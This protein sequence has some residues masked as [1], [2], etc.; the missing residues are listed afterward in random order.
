[1]YTVREN[2]VERVQSLKHRLDTHH[3]TKLVENVKAACIYLISTKNTGNYG[4]E[5]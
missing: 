2:G 3:N 1:V 4:L 5:H